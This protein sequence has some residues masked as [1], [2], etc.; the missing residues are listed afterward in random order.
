MIEA[1]FRRQIQRMRPFDT[2]RCQNKSD[3][4]VGP[5]VEIRVRTILCDIRES[6]FIVQ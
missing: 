4:E 2:K 1:V 6:G 5:E 3:S